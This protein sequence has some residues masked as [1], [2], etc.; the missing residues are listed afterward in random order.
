MDWSR[1]QLDRAAPTPLYLQL[2]TAVAN[3]IAAGSLQPGDQLPSERKLAE[4]LCLSRT[5][6]VNAYHELEAR[7]LVRSYRG[8]GTFISG[9]PERLGA[10]FAW[11]GKV[12][13]NVQ[14]HLNRG[15]RSLITLAPSDT[16]SFGAGAP[17][18]THFPAETY[19][20]LTQDVLAR[21]PKDALGFLPTEGHHHLREVIAKREGV[22]PEEVLIVSGT[23]QALDLIGR[24]LLYPQDVVVM[25]WP[26]YLGAIQTFRLAGAVLVGW[27][28]FGTDLDELEDSFVKR[29]PKLLYL[30]PSFQ[31]PTGRTLSLEQRRAI[32]D[33]AR[34]YRIPIVEDEAYRDLYFTAPPPPTLLEL[35]GDGL[36]LHLRTFSKTFAPGLRLGYVLADENIIDQ[37]SLVKAQSDLFS[38]GLS[39]LVL[40][41]LLAEGVFDAYTHHLRREHRERAQVMNDTLTA[42]FAPHAFSWQKV[43]GGLYLWTQL[44]SGNS[45]D[46]LNEATKLGVTFA[47]GEHFF[48][49]GAGKRALRLCF[50]NNEPARIVEGVN[51]L[52]EALHT[53][54]ALEVG[55]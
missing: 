35:E 29:R 55:R 31:N 23:Q 11:R 13:P 17:A 41:R 38:P 40:A 6:A 1:V 54:S 49:D 34:T 53:I 37:L 22:R 28:I 48:P 14:Q 47:L 30:N 50:A 51:R 7:G 24:C 27:D 5:T 4:R 36:V 8:R 10:Q 32:V 45:R 12:S 43:A 21:Y 25:D 46:L 33:L 20:A 3:E 19:A 16:I 15:I 44:G 42:A 39:Q 9:R 18:T 2:C 52:A 26:G